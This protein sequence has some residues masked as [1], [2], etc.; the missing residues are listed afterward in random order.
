M[1]GT[2]WT[3]FRY[4]ANTGE[5]IPINTMSHHGSSTRTIGSS[6]PVQEA[7]VIMD[8]L[9]MDDLTAGNDCPEDPLKDYEPEE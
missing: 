2:L 8:D 4:N 9:F 6:I 5:I 1:P 3:V 7:A